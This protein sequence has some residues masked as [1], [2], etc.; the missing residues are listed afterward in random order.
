MIM[1]ECHDASIC[2]MSL[3]MSF[4]Q[5][6]N[7]MRHTLD[8]WKHNIGFFLWHQL[9]PVNDNLRQDR[10]N[11]HISLLRLKPVDIHRDF[12]LQYEF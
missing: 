12:F 5:K 11:V 8:E 1:G 9:S 10:V 6:S 4:R 2:Q 7:L 3:K